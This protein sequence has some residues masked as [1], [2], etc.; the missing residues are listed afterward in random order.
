MDTVHENWDREYTLKKND[1]IIIIIIIP[2]MCTILVIRFVINYEYISILFYNVICI[3]FDKKKIKL[4]P[5]SF[6]SQ[7][8]A[9]LN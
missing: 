4:L 5:H 8:S 6:Y 7:L 2:S 3:F 1:K 9:I